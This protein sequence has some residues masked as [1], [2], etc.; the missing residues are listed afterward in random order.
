[1]KFNPKYHIDWAWSLAIK[2][3]TDADLANAFGVSERT[4]NRWKYE[5]DNSGNMI[6]GED[7]QRVLSAFGKALM[8]GKE[9]ADA[10]VE[11]CLYKRAIG[12]DIEEEERIVEYNADGSVKPIKVKRNKKPVPPD[13]MAIM[14]WLNNRKKNTGEWSQ[15]QEITLTNG[16][17][18]IEAAVRELSVD[19]AR[20]LL[21]KI[22]DAEGHA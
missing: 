14:Y 20:R 22:E 17:S 15:K 21:K 9:I 3:A 12:Y 13:V 16:N 18:G 4:I 10:K 2:G 8:E 7:G 5:Y 11:K 1:M 19:D 6:I